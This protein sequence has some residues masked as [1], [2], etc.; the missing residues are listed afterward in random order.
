MAF[1]VAAAVLTLLMFALATALATAQ[2]KTV[3]AMREGAPGVKRWGGRILV[4]V[5]LWF[6]VLAAFAYFFAHMFGV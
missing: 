4:A 1:V 5:G 3:D 6:V 2:E